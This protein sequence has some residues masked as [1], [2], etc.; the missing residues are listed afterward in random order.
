MADRI[1]NVAA[2]RAWM[3]RPL[4]AAAGVEQQE[5]PVA[6]YVVAMPIGNAADVTL[7]ALW[8]LGL[9]HWVAAEDTRVT[10]PL[11][12]RY[13]I[14]ARMIAVHE[15][16]E[17]RAASRLIA[18]LDKGERVALVTDAG[19]PAISDPGAAVV[20]AVMAAGRR[21]IPVP[22]ASSLTAALSVAGLAADGV[23]FLGFLPS[24]A[25]SRH[26]R[27]REAAARDEAFVVFEAPHRIAD[28]ARELA[29]VLAPQR[30]VVVARE[31]TKKFESIFETSAA[32]LP[33]VVGRDG[34]RGEFVLVVDAPPPAA[35]ADDAIDETTRRW[36]VALAGELPASRAA[37][38]AAKVTGRPRQALY[39]LL[40]ED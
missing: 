32:A 18:L 23:R 5:F 10:A 8:V 26:R 30:R 3:E 2:Q 31:L 14:D 4:W 7:R 22:G 11:L 20:R 37:A 39:K 19:T 17:S 13:G 1:G 34:E 6:L 38:L 28:T 29:A 15:H 36:L 12:H 24:G 25:A 21:V 33:G 16:N 35:A 40:T 9:V 27:L